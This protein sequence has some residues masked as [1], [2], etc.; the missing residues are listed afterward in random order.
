MPSTRSSILSTA[1]ARRPLVAAAALREFARGGYHGT[2]VADVAREAKI[3]PAY[4]F[5]LYS[6][7]EALFIAALEACFEGILVAIAEGADAA[8]DQSAGSTLEA[9]GDAYAHLISDRTL[10]MLQVH[11]QSVA[12]IPEIGTAL[13]SGLGRIT[14]FAKTRSGGSDA[15]VQRFIAFGQLCHLIVTTQLDGRPEDWAQLLT[16]GIRH[17]D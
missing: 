12:D 1:D 11:A 3:S 4:V 2:T 14:S 17:P 6:G 7:K 5:K 8:P 9:M 15:E 13:R 10:L 16:R